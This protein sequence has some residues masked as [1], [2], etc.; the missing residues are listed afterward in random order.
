MKKKIILLVE[1]SSD[2]IELT[3]EALRENRITNEVVVVRDGEEALDYLFM[4]G[5]YSDRS[6]EILPAV[7]LL[8]IKLPKVDGMEVLRQIRADHL[9]RFLPVVMLTSSKEEQDLINGYNLGCNSYVR[10]P[11]GFEQFNDAVKT[12]G[13]YWLLINEAPIEE[14]K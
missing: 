14:G 7:V 13:L 5:E 9:T 4:K 3:L 2:D 1:D 6:P 12:L 8:D 11:V 10:K